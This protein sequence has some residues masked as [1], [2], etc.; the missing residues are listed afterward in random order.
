ME[1]GQILLTGDD[2]EEVAF[3]VLEQAKIAGVDYLLVT[4]E[5]DEQQALI[6]RQIQDGETLTYEVLEDENE[7]KIISKYFEELLEDINLEM[8]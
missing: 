1:D 8:E 2:G 6:L 5:V 3:R 4:D 7:L